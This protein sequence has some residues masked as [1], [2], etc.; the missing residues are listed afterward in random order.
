MGITSW[1]NIKLNCFS[2]SMQHTSLSYQR[3]RHNLSVGNVTLKSNSALKKRGKYQIFMYLPTYV[4]V[5]LVAQ[6]HSVLIF[7]S[8]EF[9]ISLGLSSQ[10]DFKKGE[11]VHLYLQ[12]KQSNWSKLDCLPPLILEHYAMAEA[13]APYFGNCSGISGFD[14]A[15]GWWLAHVSTLL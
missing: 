1:K 5:S 6:L 8:L 2:P 15:A 14:L 10:V 13:A 12:G 11:N 4:P 9:P 3:G 7:F